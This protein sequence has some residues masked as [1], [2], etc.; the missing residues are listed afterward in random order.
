[1]RILFV[2]LGAIGDV[3]QAGVAVKEYRKRNSGVELDWVVGRVVKPLVDA[4]GV[5]DRLIEVN[6]SFLSAPSA[7]GR[8]RALGMSILKLA[9]QG[10]YDRVITAYSDARYGL[11]SL[12]VR[13]GTRLRF[14]RNSNRPSPLA[15]RN[16]VHEYWRLLADADAEAIDVA[17]ATEAL[18][19]VMRNI[20]T[21][22]LSF[23]LAPH[24]VAIAAGGAKN[25]YRDDALRR[26]PIERYLKVAERLLADGRAVVLVGAQ[27]DNW[28]STAFAGLPVIDLIGKTSLLELIPILDAS[29]GVVTNDSGI[30]HLSSLTRTGIV[31][32]FGPTPANACIPFGRQRTI[33]LDPGNRISCSPCYDGRSYADCSK[34]VC[35]EAI[36][37]D[38]VICAIKSICPAPPHSSCA[39]SGQHGAK[40]DAA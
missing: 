26:W 9:T 35:L 30:M 25:A 22:S 19:A 37:V 33:A 39:E 7:I 18:G 4:F 40:G 5:A 17:A 3:V 31:A 1:M 13:S 36:S 21:P 14:N 27:S 24:Y 8:I 34:N 12:G 32:L 6:E 16:R 23:H 11:L 28:V 38:Q 29:D 15:H 20:A 10:R 2:K